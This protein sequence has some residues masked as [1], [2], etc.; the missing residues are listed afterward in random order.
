MSDKA[1]RKPAV[2]K[3]ERHLITFTLLGGGEW[4]CELLSFTVGGY[5]GTEAKRL[6][7]AKGRRVR[8]PLGPRH[9]LQC[10]MA[11]GQRNGR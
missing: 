10:C 5:P 9:R 2:M 6:S 4:S 3:I 1:E 11:G 7:M 8:A